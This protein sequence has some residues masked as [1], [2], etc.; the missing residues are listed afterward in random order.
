MQS[1]K[2]DDGW[3][4]CGGVGVWLVFIYRLRALGGFL[5]RVVGCLV[6]L[7]GFVLSA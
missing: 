7:D 5:M 2:N 4:V 1:R 3:G 6:G